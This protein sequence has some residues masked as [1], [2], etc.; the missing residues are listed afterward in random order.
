MSQQKQKRLALAA[1]LNEMAADLERRANE[2]R[3]ASAFVAD[4]N[5]DHRKGGSL[6]SGLK[7]GLKSAYDIGRKI[8][9]KGKDIYAKGKALSDKLKE[10]KIISSLGKAAAE[11]GL[12]GVST[13]GK[14]VEEVAGRAG[15]GGPKLARKNIG[16]SPGIVSMP[17]RR[18][19][20]GRKR[21]IK[22]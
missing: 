17:Q 20:G 16:M 7:K 8:Y 5:A 21:K 22:A 6:F 9:D 13:V 3:E 15:Y 1:E 4:D 19:G 2:C 18:L 12:P 11:S 14:V 10:S